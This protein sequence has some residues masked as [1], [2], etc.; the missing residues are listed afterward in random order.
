MPCPVLPTMKP[1]R[2]ILAL[3]LLFVLVGGL[4]LKFWPEE[5]SVAVAK[6][7]AQETV[8][9]PKLKAPT[10]AAVELPKTTPVKPGNAPAIEPKHENT[11]VGPPTAIDPSQ[12]ENQEVSRNDIREA[13]GHELQLQLQGGENPQEWIDRLSQPPP[14]PMD[15]GEVALADGVSVSKTV[16]NGDVVT[17]T[18]MLDADGNWTVNTT[19]KLDLGGKIQSSS[20]K[21]KVAPDKPISILTGAI[22]IVYFT[23][24]TR[25]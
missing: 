18:P 5:N 19:I 20:I 3:I 22:Y 8:D 6:S 9:A 13:M 23:P 14:L 21:T 17:L 7:S 16:D 1:P 4:A 10:V 15:F 12:L 11:A 2:S 25:S 24:R